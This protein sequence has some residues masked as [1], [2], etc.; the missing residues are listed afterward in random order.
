MR[1]GYKG[2]KILCGR[3]KLLHIKSVDISGFKSFADRTKLTFADGLTAVVGPNGSGKSNISDAVRWVLGEQSTKQ[4]RGKS[5]EDVIFDGAGSRKPHGFC[6]VTIDFDNKDRS[7]Q[8]DADEV[9]ITRRYY[10]SHESEYLIN[11]NFVRL[12]DIHELFMDTGLGRD[13]YSMIG[14]GKIDNIVSSKSDERRDIF[15]EASGIS[16]YRYRK[17]ESERKLA[18][19]Q[20]NLLRLQDI[21]NELKDRV[22]PL[23]KQSEDAQKFLE[24]AKEKKE[25]E[26]G[27][28]LNTLDS[29]TKRF[30]TLEEKIAT[31]TSQ[32][33]SLNRRSDEIEN[34]IENNSMMFSK[35]TVDID[36]L[37][38]NA[39]TT[40]QKVA[41][42]QGEI[43][44]CDTTIEHNNADINRLNAEMEAL[45]NADKLTEEAIRAKKSELDLSKTEA[46]K[47]KGSIAQAQEE[48]S[49]LIS[50]SENLLALKE[51]ASL[52]LNEIA[53]KISQ[54][55]ADYQGLISA[56]EELLA[57]VPSFA[58]KKEA[59]AQVVERLEKEFTQLADDKRKIEDDITS[60]GNSKDGIALKLDVK[61]AS[62]QKLLGEIEEKEKQRDDAMRRAEM[63]EELD[64]NLD[65]FSLAVKEVL[66]AKEHRTLSGICGVV[67]R[68]INVKSEYAVA[69]ETALGAAGAHIIVENDGNAKRAI[70]FLKEKH[71]GRATFLPVS[72]IK[73]MPLSEKGL[74]GC[75]GFIGFA[76][77][78]VDCDSKYRDVIS[79]LLC[80]TVICDN[81][82]NAVSIAKKYGNRFKTVSLDGQVVNQGGSL[83]G[84]SA[85]KSAGMLSRRDDIE[86]LKQKALTIE[87][88]IKELFSK[89]QEIT[90]ARETLEAQVL[91]FDSVLLTGKEDMIRIEV[92]ERRLSELLDTAKAALSDIETEESA[93]AQRIEDLEG[94]SK[95]AK[96]DIES[97]ESAAENIRNRQPI[98]S[99]DTAPRRA[100]LSDILTELRLKLGVLE[101]DIEI[102]AAAIED[103][104]LSD[105]ERENKKQAIQDQ[106]TGLKT[107]N[108]ELE[109]KKETYRLNIE[110]IKTEGK[111]LLSDSDDLAKKREE[112]DAK[113]VQLRQ[114]ER[115]IAA[116]K[117]NISGEIARLN[118]RKEVMQ[119]ELDDIVAKLYD[120]YELTRT[121]AQELGIVIEDL[122]TAKKRLSTIKSEIKSLGS[123]NVAA[124]DEYKEV[125]E[126]YDFLSGQIADVEKSK[127]ELNKLIAQLQEQMK[128]MF[129]EGFN[130]IG[131]EFTRTFTQMFGGGHAQLV[132]TD[133]DNILTS[134]IDIV[135]Q[136][137]GKKVPS[138][139]SLSGG[140]KAL[141]AISIYFAIMEVNCPP[142]CFLDEVETALDDINVERF[143]NYM[144]TCKLPTQF[145]CITHRRGTME[146]ADMLYGVTMQ[147]KG[148]TKTIELNVNELE[149][150]FKEL[151]VE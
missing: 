24:L 21:E 56:K 63:L 113:N 115:K 130:K 67:S 70:A 135:A 60:A 74:E 125:K 79:W 78:L 36:N 126:R 68:L 50:K 141:I 140:E 16:K 77:K 146:S 40:D 61:R 117:E 58:S 19:A 43:A 123:V 1:A 101:K 47:I 82:D 110:D 99:D 57:S 35:F 7:L 65:S 3:E 44:V 96:S 4:L 100:Q 98:D 15:E 85:A 131:K 87:K 41:V 18:A 6:E 53:D 104:T 137:P 39:G 30:Q 102:T 49:S 103:M 122:P 25:L 13:G 116:D 46:E 112:L 147:E 51:S 150:Q 34:E 26:I 45:E 107:A 11:G 59:A 81:L 23:K 28:W 93:T 109:S 143:A 72:T 64:R 127:A 8:F 71:A 106:I 2:I 142:F 69:V 88:E 105:S 12:K 94:L 73:P 90:A 114:D 138:L 133:P 118:E 42:M 10:R 151:K 134:G 124:I 33:E 145:I 32:Y 132:L 62:E 136:L 89:T 148:V 37:K 92:E 75:E 38:E 31:A 128:T 80:R 22:G 83:T 5:M 9:A 29:S 27:V 120:E 52:S 149:K 111:Q 129:T 144:K 91:N 17:E 119:R 139:E 86:K 54:R 76:D 48:L 84:G 97:L 95:K 20:E 66:A 121:E 55:K 108:A 14:Q